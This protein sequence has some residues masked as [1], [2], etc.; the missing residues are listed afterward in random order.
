MAAPPFELGAVNATDK[1]PLEAVI[2]EIAGAVA[3]DRQGFVLYSQS[4]KG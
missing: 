2:E 3:T 1:E 4:K